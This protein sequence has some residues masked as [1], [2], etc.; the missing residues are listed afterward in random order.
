MDLRS[1]HEHRR[2]RRDAAT[3]LGAALLGRARDRRPS[4]L[5]RTFDTGPLTRVTGSFG[6]AQRENPHFD[7][8]DRRVEGTRA[9]RAPALRTRDPRRGC[10]AGRVTF[11]GLRDERLDGCVPM[12]VRHAATIPRIPRTPCSLRARWTRLNGVS[13]A[14]GGVDGT[15]RYEL[16]ARGYK[17]CLPPQR[18]SRCAPIRHGVGAAAALRAVSAR[19][20]AASR[21]ARRAARGRRRLLW[22][23]SCA[24][25]SRAS[26]HRAHRIHRLHGRRRGRAVWCVGP[27]GAHGARR[28][29]RAVPRSPRW[30]G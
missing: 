4:K 30:S 15:N 2:R 25:R 5:D 18:C 16:D 6:I 24:Y 9:R 29:R 12:H 7:L 17:R 14:L 1:P 26:E 27:R 13:A 19:R 20:L 23:A 22:T 10:V 11:G 8:D 3:C 21:H 28:R